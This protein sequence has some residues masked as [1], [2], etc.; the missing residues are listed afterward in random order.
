MISPERI[1]EHADALFDE[2]I[3]IRRHLHAHPELSFQETA[4]SAFVSEELSRAGIA[5]TTGVGGNGIVATI[6]DSS[7]AVAGDQEAARSADR[8]TTAG[9]VVALRADMDALPIEEAT[10]HHFPSTLNGVMHA[11][12]HDAHTTCLLIAAR[13]LAARADELAGTVKL[14]FQPAE[15]RAPGGARSM[16]EAGALENPHVDSVFGQ[17]V[18][19]E[20][21]VGSVGFNPGL[22]MASADELYITIHGRGGH[23]AKPH[24]DIDPVVIA[25]NLVVTLQQ[26]V[27]RNADPTVPSVL[28][29]GRM[30]GAGAANVIP[31]TV[32]LAGTFRTV[33]D[34][35]REQALKRIEQTTRTLV[36]ALGGEADVRIVRGYPPVVNDPHVTAG[37]R[38]LAV[39]YLGD[40]Y[41]VDLP[42]AMWSEDFAY[43]GAERPSCFYNL[44]VRNDGRGIVHP[45]HTARF[46]IDE[47]AL[48]VGSGLMAWI[49]AGSLKPHRH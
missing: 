16:V 22:F 9:P 41:V 20:L 44:G 24:Q 1:R 39:D 33:D 49:A 5:H 25:S 32:E 35:W 7:Q 2:A 8:N 48:R 12:G 45:V 23:A 30:I 38:Q 34:R 13:I 15:E 27:S 21:P 3:R 28:S 19:T 43:F 36:G 37:A 11:C 47:E 46:D 18:N 14:I 31:D 17:H 4:T 26:I 42:P 6:G 10:T 29:F 40:E